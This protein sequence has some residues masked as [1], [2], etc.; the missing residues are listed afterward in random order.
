MA[1]ANS[2][3][4]VAVVFPTH[5]LIDQAL[6]SWDLKRTLELHPVVIESFRPRSFFLEQLNLYQEQRDRAIEADILFCTSVSVIIDQRMRGGYNGSTDREV[7]IFDEAD[8]LPEFAALTSEISISRQE[9][10]ELSIKEN[11]A[12]TTIRKILSKEKA[13]SETKAKARLI[14]EA[15]SLGDVWF[16]KVGFA[17]DGSLELRSR[18]PGRLLRRISNRASTIFVSA[19]LSIGGTFN[20]FRRAM[21]IDE[22]SRLSDRIEP[23]KHGDL[24]FIFSTDEELGSEEWLNAICDEVEISEHPTLVSTPSHA[25]ATAIGERLSSA[26]VRE[27]DETTSQAAMRMGN[28][29]VLVAAG[30]WAGLD[31]PIQWK[32]IVVP[33]VPYTGPKNLREF[34]YEDEEEF[35]EQ[36]ADK[37]SSYISSKNAAER[38]LIQVFGRGLRRPDSE[39]SIVIC[40]ARIERFSK[41]APKRFQK[42]YFEGLAI[43]THATRS[44]RSRKLRKDA[45]LH[46]GEECMACGFQPIVLRQLEVHHLDPLA[47]RGPGTTTLDDVAVLCRNCHGLAHSENPPIPLVEL[48]KKTKSKNSQLPG[49]VMG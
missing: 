46:H 35:E 26:T 42:A 48:K 2:G 15:L 20:D 10:S 47:D 22:Q 11:N 8:Q 34:W 13:P 23:A 36:K 41:I 39:C 6:A 31:T 4:R 33:K 38:R 1:A 24:Q 14:E 5:Q 32:T 9:L 25:L 43:S 12:K 45:L 29:D 37:L 16:L 44:E 49:I 17:E 27:A 18:L 40:D 30:A 21:G 28:A 3:K 7:I 19:T